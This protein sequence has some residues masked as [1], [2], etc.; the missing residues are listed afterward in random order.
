MGGLFKSIHRNA[1]VMAQFRYRS[2]CGLESNFLDLN[3]CTKCHL[4]SC[5]QCQDFEVV[6]KY[7]S[8]CG[9]DASKNDAVYCHKN[10]FQCPCCAMS[11]QIISNKDEN[12]TDHRSYSFKC[13]GCNWSYCTPV[14]PKIKSLT[15]YIIELEYSTDTHRRFESLRQFYHTRNTLNSLSL[16]P[17]SLKFDALDPSNLNSWWKRLANGEPLWKLINEENAIPFDELKQENKHWLPSLCKL[18]PKYNYFCP[19]CKRCM[20]RMDPTPDTV[21]WVKT[22]PIYSGIPRISVISSYQCTQ[23]YKEFDHDNNLMLLIENTR[24]DSNAT[25]KI[26]AEESLLV[27]NHE[28]SIF[29]AIKTNQKRKDNLEQLQDVLHSL[30]THMLNTSPDSDK[31]LRVE[32]T[33]RLGLLNKRLS[34]DNLRIIDEGTGWIVIPLMI[35]NRKPRY[36]ID[37]FVHFEDWDL[38]MS[39][40]I[41]L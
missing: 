8:Q 32:N 5:Q 2:G 11:L 39:A 27:P 15:K 21:K 37:I 35:I 10:C 18:R 28:L 4:I 24:Q 1:E 17:E 13:Q 3:L 34:S 14:V 6:G 20:T 19:Y 25:L 7:C 36:E 33:R 38:S 31:L 30:P 16:K 23:L 22:P 40:F 29:A 26:N 12:N 41:D 9:R